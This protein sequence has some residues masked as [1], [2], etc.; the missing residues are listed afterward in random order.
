MEKLWNRGYTIIVH[1]H[2]G[3]EW[4]EA[5]CQAAR[6][7]HFVTQYQTKPQYYVDDLPVEQWY[8]ERVYRD[9]EP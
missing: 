4:A 2:T 8:G 1:S 7:D 3:A 9:Y 5:V 6:A